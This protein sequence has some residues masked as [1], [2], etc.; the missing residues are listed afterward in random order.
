MSTVKASRLLE[1][2]EFLGLNRED[3]AHATGWHVDR[4]I[5]L[6]DG[7]GGPITG[8]ELRKLSRLYRRPVAWFS[9]ETTYQPSP[10]LLRQVENLGDGDRETILDFAEWLEGAGPPPKITRADLDRMPDDA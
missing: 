7:T 3:V 6:E 8:L 2:R 10:D 4:V 9:G 5:T 1:A